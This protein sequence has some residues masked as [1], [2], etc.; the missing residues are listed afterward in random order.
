MKNWKHHYND[1][2]I[3]YTDLGLTNSQILSLMLDQGHPVSAA[4]IRNARHRLGI[5]GKKQS[6]Q[7]PKSPTPTEQPTRLPN[8]RPNPLQV[9]RQWFGIRLEERTGSYWLDG[10]PVNLNTIIRSLNKLRVS[11]G[12]EQYADNPNWRV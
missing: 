10:H 8:N 3:K 9:A 5:G 2:V 7:Q 12:L 1:L 11:Q 6:T 4:D